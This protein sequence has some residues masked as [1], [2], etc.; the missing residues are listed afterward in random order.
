[1]TRRYAGMITGIVPESVG[2]RCG[3]QA[4]DKLLAINDMSLRDIIDVRIFS[5]RGIEKNP[6]AKLIESDEITKTKRNL[7]DEIR[8]LDTEKGRRI[9]TLL[10]GLA[11]IKDQKISGV[12]LKKGTKLTLADGAARPRP[13]SAPFRHRRVRALPGRIQST[14]ARACDAI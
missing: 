10:K 14:R 6:R 4:G 1:M 3:L 2:S 7:D 13:S 8:I 11:I 9:R 12:E 5:R